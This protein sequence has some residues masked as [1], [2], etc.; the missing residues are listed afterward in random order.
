MLHCL[1]MRGGLL[2]IL[3]AAGL[4]PGILGAEGLRDTR[5]VFLRA[6]TAVAE[7]RYREAL[8][9]Y[10]RVLEQ[11]PADAVVRYEYAQLLRDLNVQDEALKQA[12]EAVRLDSLLPEAHR[13]L[14]TLELAGAES[15][16]SRLDRAIEELRR[17]RQLTPN[18]VATAATLARALVSRG[19]PAEAARVLDDVPEARTQPNLIRL[20]A[21]ARARS[22]RYREAENLYRTMLEADP[23]DREVQSALIELYEEEDRID[24]ALERLRDLEKIDPENPAI[25]ERMTLDLARAGRF[26][27]AEKRARELASKRPENRAIRRLLAEVLFEKGDGAAGEKILRDLLATDSEDDMS[28]RALAGELLRGRRFVEART[29]LEESLRR[30]G[31]DPKSAEQRRSATVELGY[32]ALLRKDYAAAKKTL[33]P[34]A[35]SGSSVNARATRILLTVARETEDAPYGLAKTKAATA[36]ERDNPEWVAAVAEFRFRAGDRAGAQ[37]ALGRLAAS[38][39]PEG[40]LAAA[41]AY[42]RLKEYADAARVARDACQRFPENSEALFRLGSSLERSGTPAEA[43]K[44]FLKLLELKPNDAAA[45]NYLGY[46][47][48]D[49]GVHL[50]QARDLLEKAVARDPRNGAYRDSLGWAYFRLGVLEAAEKNLV[51][52]HQAEPDDP[53]IEEHLGD[54]SERQGNLEKALGHWDRALELKHEE[55]EKV[56]Q[57]LSRYRPRTSGR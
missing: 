46:M 29:L 8:E 53:T 47:W 3:L 44:V 23:T 57:K 43:E 45:A 41:G 49:R 38:E 27:E 42:A 1:V 50:E 36:V 54:L 25:A 21:Q 15:D 7:G 14:G 4:L 40:V 13:L 55:P 12:R 33:E 39:D 48:A 32:L 30:A 16:P 9:L 17:A 24:L 51:E 28:R 22:G 20:S 34:I 5:R 19:R 10:R 35:T 37:E 26:E 52:A 56:R 2:P 11:I 6:R 18:D 31:S